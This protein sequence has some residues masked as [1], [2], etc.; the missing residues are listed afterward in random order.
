SFVYSHL[1]NIEA[2]EKAQ[3]AALRLYPPS[4]MRGPIKIELQR[5]LC[6]A[7]SGD[8]NEGAR[9]AT[10]ALERLPIECRTKFETGL[11]EQVLTAIPPDA[12]G[13]TG[14]EELREL[15]QLDVTH[16]QHKEI[17]S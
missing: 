13:R 9:H 15:I 3:Q 4:S 1:G 10:A 12:R 6:L 8:Y 5:A 2:A 17:Q 7:R 14:P 16:K 11:G